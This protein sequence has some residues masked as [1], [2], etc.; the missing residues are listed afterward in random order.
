MISPCGVRN[1]VRGTYVP[2]GAYLAPVSRFRW[3]SSRTMTSFSA[4]SATAGN[5][6]TRL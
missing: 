6:K 5:E 2:S 3:A 1:K 4:A